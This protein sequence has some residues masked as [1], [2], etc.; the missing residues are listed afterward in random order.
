MTPAVAEFPVGR[1][2][3]RQSADIYTMAFQINDKYS[4]V[5]WFVISTLFQQIPLALRLYNQL[6][7]LLYTRGIKKEFLI[8]N[9]EKHKRI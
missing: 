9:Y 1:D 4:D 2:L 8:M 7:K 5:F 6:Q 3:S